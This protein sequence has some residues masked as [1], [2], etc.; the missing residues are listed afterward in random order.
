MAD[1]LSK[2]SY[3]EYYFFY[4]FLNYSRHCGLLLASLLLVINDAS[5][6]AA[7]DIPNSLPQLN[8]L[9]EQPLPSNNLSQ[10][11]NNKTGSRE[12]T[13][14]A[15]GNKTLKNTEQLTATQGYKVE[16]Y[17]SAAD[18][19][20]QVRSIEPKAFVKGNIIQVGIFSRQSNA[21]DMVRKLAAE[22]LWSRIVTN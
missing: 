22:G 18:L 12:Y 13:F 7:K 15:P 6:I 17:G 21:E 10:S 3:V 14:K 4:M 11:N 19:L 9:N 5:S 20:L 1:Y 16:V 2:I 8:S